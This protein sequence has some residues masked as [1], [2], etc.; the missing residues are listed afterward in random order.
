MVG[1]NVYKVVGGMHVYI[2]TNT[3]L[4][5]DQA[6]PSLS[7]RVGFVY[8]TST[9]KT[10]GPY[11]LYTCARAHTHESSVERDVVG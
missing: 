4:T 7:L 8:T 2:T 9:R 1:V 5:C 6:K 10:R 3:R 11:G